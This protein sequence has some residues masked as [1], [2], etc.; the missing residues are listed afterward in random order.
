MRRIAW[1]VVQSTLFRWSPP[2]WY[3]WRNCWLRW[4][5]ANVIDLPDAPARTAPTVKV[6]FPWNLTIKTGCLIGPDCIVYNLGHITLNEGANISRNVHLCSGS[7]DFSRW[8]MPLT[9]A[10]IEIG[11]N[12]WIATD[13]FVGPGVSIGDE[14]VVG[15]RSVVVNSLPAGMVCVGHPCVPL[16][17]RPSLA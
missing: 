4:F 6:Y 11:K 3:S 15:A 16:K 17:K 8:D 9:T 12:V 5:G 10:S 13:C 14:A 2:S 1:L 7:H